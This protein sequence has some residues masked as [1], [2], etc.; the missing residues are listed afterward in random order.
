[1]RRSREFRFEQKVKHGEL[2]EIIVETETG[3]EIL[4]SKD[5]FRERTYRKIEK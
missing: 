5:D 3:K 1:M 2:K 4:L